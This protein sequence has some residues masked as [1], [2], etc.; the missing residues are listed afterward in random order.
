MN[1][2]SAPTILATDNEPARII[3][4]QNVPFLASTSTSEANLNNTFNQI[5]RQDVGISLE[6]T[7]QISSSS[8]VTMNM[9]TEVSSIVGATINS[10]LGPTTTKRQSETT[11]IAKDGQMIVT[12]GLLADDVSESKDGTPFLEEVPLFGH[13]F[14]D[15]STA[16]RRTNLLIFI[17]PRIVKDQYDIRDVTYARKEQMKGEMETNEIFPARR[18]VL[19][20][21]NMDKVTEIEDYKGDAP[22]TILPP[23]GGDPKPAAQE[24]HSQQFSPDSRGVIE[25]KVRPKLPAAAAGAEPKGSLD[26][27][28]SAPQAA[29]NEGGDRFVV[30]SLRKA[31]P[32]GLRLPFA[33]DPDS[34]S[35][36][37]VIPSGSA[38]A[39]RDFFESGRSYGYA[40]GATTVQAIARGVFSSREEAQGAFPALSGSWYTLSPFEIMGLGRGPWTRVSTH[41]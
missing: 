4:G 22:S 21:R 36:G 25:L 41:N 6:M 9:F 12:G 16:R 20:N 2:L 23:E 10:S 37:I 3:V 15:H 18:E 13:L 28:R 39:A 29:R 33:I 38:A 8:Y 19:N 27:A 1:V 5:E 30:F 17:T 11:V 7:P 26:P 40:V 32:E 31:P 34:E 24:M 14:R 35:F